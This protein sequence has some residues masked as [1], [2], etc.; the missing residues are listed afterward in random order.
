MSLIQIQRRAAPMA[1]VTLLCFLMTLLPMR[2]ARAQ[3]SPPPAPDD[4]T[5]TTPISDGTQNPSSLTLPAPGAETPD[6]DT[7]VDLSTGAAKSRFAFQLPKARGD[8][9]PAL[10]LTYSSSVGVGFAGAGWTLSQPSIV[11][12]GA[13]GMPRFTDDVF[14]ATAAAQSAA[15]ATFDSYLVDGQLLVPICLIGSCPTGTETLPATLAGTSIAGWAYFRR[16]VD[17]GARYFFAPNGLT[18]IKQE[19]SGVVTQFGHPLD[20]AS[21]DPS[22]SDGLEKTYP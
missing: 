16:E 10:A 5:A 11:R 14:T 9:Q 17:D 6:A 13:A 20:T 3:S 2:A 4:I 19:K 22:L 7:S 21:V 15:S 12:R 18:W 1:T 8:A